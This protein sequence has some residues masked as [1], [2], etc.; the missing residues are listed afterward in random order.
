M[1]FLTA[2]I[3]GLFGSF[4][5]AGM[6]GPIAFALPRNR[7]AG[8]S[9][10]LGRFYYN[11]GRIATYA[12]LGM[13]SGFFGFGL[14]LAGF[15]HGLSIAVGFL[16]LV[17]LLYQHFIRKGAGINPFNWISGKYIKKLFGSNNYWA[18]LIIG[19]LNGLLPCGFVYMAIMGA[20][21]TQNASDGALFMVCFGL[22]TFPMMYGVSILG[23]FLSSSVRSKLSKLSPVFAIT[24]ALIFIVRGL[25]LGIPYLSP[26]APTSGE[27]I[28]NC[29]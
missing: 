10:Y 21:V 19:L 27:K 25:N 29:E 15:Q 26:K 4:H 11:S 22:G 24:I 20:S 14:R 12:F 9:F 17:V 7:E 13:I 23:Q 8:F 16:I 18:L 6:C 2:F 1:L 3:T 5:C 28:E